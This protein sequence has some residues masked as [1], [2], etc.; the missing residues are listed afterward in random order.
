MSHSCPRFLLTFDRFFFPLQHTGIFA[1]IILNKRKTKDRGLKVVQK[2]LKKGLVHLPHYSARACIIYYT[3]SFLTQVSTPFNLIHPPPALLCSCQRLPSFVRAH[4]TPALHLSPP[5]RGGHLCN[6]APP[7][8]ALLS[9]S[10]RCLQLRPQRAFLLAA[11]AASLLLARSLPLL[12]PVV[13]LSSSATL[14]L[15]HVAY[16][17][18]TSLGEAG[19]LCLVYKHA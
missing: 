1:S 6:L 18:P 5:G 11:L 10:A 19:P 14:D 2:G 13:L 17:P 12:P 7:L 16:S 15:G 4:H 8:P 9:A 3:L